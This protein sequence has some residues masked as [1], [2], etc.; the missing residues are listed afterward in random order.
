MTVVLNDAPGL[1]KTC[2]SLLE[3]AY[4]NWE[5][6]IIYGPSSDETEFIAF[7]LASQDHRIRAIKEE[8]SGIYTSM[9]QGLWLAK[10]TYVWFMNA[11]DTFY[12]QESLILGQQAIDRSE[13]AYV[14]GGYQIDSSSKKQIM[15][16]RDGDFS[17]S[18][19]A[20]TPN[21]CHQAIIFDT[22]KVKLL[23]GYDT[24]YRYASDYDL[25]LRLTLRF[26]NK[27]ISAILAT[28]NAGGTADNNLTKVHHEKFKIRKKILRSKGLNLLSHAWF[29]IIIMKLTLN[30]IRKNIKS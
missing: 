4:E 23:G 29:L 14:S 18:F 13:L 12:N 16:S 24:K 2:Q 7:E 10:G 20:F 21:W 28:F 30:K 25:I 6:I 15:K 26:S 5:Q 3:Q 11:G 27:R 1:L 8:E 9:N 17:Y 19:F 22:Y